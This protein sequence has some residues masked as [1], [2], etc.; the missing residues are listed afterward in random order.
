MP[1]EWWVLS[2]LMIINRIVYDKEIY[3]FFYFKISFIQRY[4]KKNI[5]ILAKKY[6]IQVGCFI[7]NLFIFLEKTSTSV[8][9][10]S[11]GKCFS[12][13]SRNFR[14]SHLLYL[15]LSAFFNR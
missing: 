3:I 13:V 5:I 14:L 12:K 1:D 2:F 11:T 7:I 9:E 4:L 8:D 10:K 6:F 15:S